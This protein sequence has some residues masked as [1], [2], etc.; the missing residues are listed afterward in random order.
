MFLVLLSLTQLAVVNVMK[1]KKYA[2]ALAY[3]AFVTFDNIVVE[4]SFLTR[5]GAG[6]NYR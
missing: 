4:W 1:L 2:C 5:A 3:L 6:P